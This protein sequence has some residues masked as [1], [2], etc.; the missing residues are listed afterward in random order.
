LATSECGTCHV[1]E[2]IGDEVQA[3][4]AILAF[5]LVKRVL[6][7]LL[8]SA[9]IRLLASFPFLDHLNDLFVGKSLLHLTVLCLGGLYIIPGVF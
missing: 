6:I 2:R 3:P 4:P 5:V 7:D 8:P 1:C 9:H